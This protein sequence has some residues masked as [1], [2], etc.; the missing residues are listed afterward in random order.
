MVILLFICLTLLV[1]ILWSACKVSNNCSRKEEQEETIR[2]LEGKEYMLDDYRLEDDLVYD[3]DFV[4]KEGR[5][6]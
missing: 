4:K 2:R 6:K 5:K 3:D 1:F